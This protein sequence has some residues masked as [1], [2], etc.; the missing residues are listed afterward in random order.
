MKDLVSTFS[1]LT[2]ITQKC[3]NQKSANYIEDNFIAFIIGKDEANEIWHKLYDIGI[4]IFLK[5]M[6]LEKNAVLFIPKK[7]K[8]LYEMC[9]IFREKRTFSLNEYLLDIR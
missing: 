2:H 3:L 9:C 5:E 7:D 4:N 6:P 1:I 8:T